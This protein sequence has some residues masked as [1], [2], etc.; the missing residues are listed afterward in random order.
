MRLVRERKDLPA[1]GRGC[2]DILEAIVKW[3]YLLTLVS[4]RVVVRAKMAEAFPRTQLGLLLRVE[5][6]LVTCRDFLAVDWGLT[7]ASPESYASAQPSL[8]SGEAASHGGAPWTRIQ[9]RRFYNQRRGAPGTL[10]V[11]NDDSDLE[12]KLACFVNYAA[13]LQPR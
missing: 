1:T 11:F 3:C 10:N 5:R 4:S 9:H 6:T 2:N 8:T 12:W 13:T 7:A